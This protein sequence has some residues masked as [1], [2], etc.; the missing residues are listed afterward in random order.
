MGNYLLSIADYIV[1]NELVPVVFAIGFLM[2]YTRK[3]FKVLWTSLAIFSV[4]FT[5]F[6][7]SQP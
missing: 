1:E 4:S 2:I 3:P 7:L 6:T 5:L